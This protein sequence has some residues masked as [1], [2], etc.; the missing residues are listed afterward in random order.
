MQQ[1]EKACCEKSEKSSSSWKKSPTQQ[2][3]PGWI[4]STIIHLFRWRTVIFTH[5]AMSFSRSNIYVIAVTLWEFRIN[6]L[7]TYPHDET[8]N[9]RNENEIS[10]QQKKTRDAIFTRF[11]PVFGS[12][13]TCK[14]FT[15]DE[16][17]QIIVLKRLHGAV[18]LFW[19]L[20]FRWY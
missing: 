12:T 8:S 6:R 18:D 15:S 5:F 4:S 17:R 13:I 16:R 20:F 1:R 7:H 11:P 9:S 10:P 3:H 2:Q 14:R 19:R